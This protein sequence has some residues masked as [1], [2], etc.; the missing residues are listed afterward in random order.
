MHTHYKGLLG[1][2]A[3]AC[4]VF[5]IVLAAHASEQETIALVEKNTGKAPTFT[6]IDAKGEKQTLDASKHKLTA[7]HFWATWCVPCVDELPMVDDAAKIF[8]EKGLHVVAVS[9][10]G[11]RMDKV[12]KF[13]AE[14]KIKTL[15]PYIDPT[16]KTSKTAGLRGLPGT[17]FI[18]SKGNVIARADGPLDWQVDAVERFLTA[19]L[20]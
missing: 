11:K 8:G 20:K 16:L 4:L 14:N 12:E 19:R 3:S 1:V 13:F 15:T 18:D 6:Y 9:L 10:D 5:F 7:L 2:L 17:L